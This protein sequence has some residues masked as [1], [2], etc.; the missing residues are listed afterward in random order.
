DGF[1]ASLQSSTWPDAEL[2]QAV[3]DFGSGKKGIVVFQRAGLSNVLPRLVRLQQQT[4]ETSALY[5][6]VTFTLAFLGKDYR[7]NVR[8]LI[9]PIVL[10]EAHAR[11]WSDYE[12]TGAHSPDVREE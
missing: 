7:R 6:Y 2:K 12:E 5:R 10:Y 11:N 4:P 1:A 8:Q 3:R 9:K